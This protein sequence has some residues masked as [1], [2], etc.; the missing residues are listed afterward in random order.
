MK[1]IIN[2]IDNCI[3]F[4]NENINILEISDAKLFSHIIQTLNDKINK[5]ESNEIVLLDEKENEIDMGKNAYIVLDVFNIDYNSKKILDKIY[6]M[7]EEQIKENQDYTIEKIIENLKEYLISEINELPFEFIMQD[8]LNVTKLLKI[9]ELKLDSSC[10]S[11]ILEKLEFLID[12]LSYLKIAKILIIPNLKEFLTG[13]EI[14][15][16]YK[17]A[18]YN[19]IKLMV[20]ERENKIKLEYEKVLKIDENYDDFIY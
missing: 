14:V 18:L 6:G 12:I 15:E 16:F 5:I 19:N 10:Y 20:V 1:L 8:Y 17:Y 11:T 9:F 4:E 7:I 3:N 2:G 13:K